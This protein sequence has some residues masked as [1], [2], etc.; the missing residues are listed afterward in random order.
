MKKI[1]L[2]LFLNLILICQKSYSDELVPG[3][4]IGY[5]HFG[6]N[7][8]LQYTQP[9][10]DG[11]VGILHKGWDDL[12]KNI[13]ISGVSYPNYWISGLG[14]NIKY[15][16]RKFQVNKQK[17]VLDEGTERRG[18][19]VWEKTADLGT[20]AEGLMIYAVPTVYYHFFRES[21]ISALIGFGL[22]LVYVNAKGDIYLT[23]S[24]GRVPS[25]ATCF[26][27]ISNNDS[28]EDINLYC[29]KKQIN[30]NNI[31]TATSVYFNI[32]G[33]NVGFEFGWVNASFDKQDK[34]DNYGTT[35]SDLIG[36]IYYQINF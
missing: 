10:S 5:N 15:A 33:G 7:I 11:R 34:D 25:N 32:Q 8:D 2:I 14:W 36:A 18:N 22:G 35:L 12:T 21:P 31:A 23:D 19:H 20:S 26:N 28:Y 4:R 1:S 9:V 6:D 3:I 16:A 17:L 24:Y 27:Y 30:R 13:Y 29:E